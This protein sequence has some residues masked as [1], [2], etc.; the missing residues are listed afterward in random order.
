MQ[1]I[2]FFFISFLIIG[3]IFYNGVLAWKRGN[4]SKKIIKKKNKETK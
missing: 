1:K 3:F 2:I 4:E